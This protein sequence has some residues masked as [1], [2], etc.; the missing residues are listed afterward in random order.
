[1]A[2]FHNLLFVEL[3]GGLGDVLIALAAMQSL[4]RSHPQARLTVLTFAPGGELL[5]TDPLVHQVSY[6]PSGQAYQTV[7]QLLTRQSFDLIVSD[8]SYEGIDR[9]IQA[10]RARRTVTN[11]WRSP[12]PDQ[13][14]SDRFLAILLQEGL[15]QP[16]AIQPAQLHLEDREHQWARACLKPS[17]RP[18]IVLIPD[19]GMAIKRWPVANFIQLGQQLRHQHGATILVP[20]GGDEAGARTI[21]ASIPGAQG[22]PSVNLRQ[23]AALLAQADLVVAADTGPARIAAAVGTPTITLFGPSWAGRYGQPAPHINLQG[24]PACPER[25]IANFTE[26][27]CWYAGTCP[28]EAWQTCL[29][30]ISVKDVLTTVQTLL[31]LRA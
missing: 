31:P 13:F 11:L 14:V 6:A 15:I 25:N 7:A 16:D 12:P 26:Q 19:A 4:A 1:M 10:S 27:A 21:V 29:E 22:W 3:L 30:A 24:L 5:E 9:L 20:V 17:P 2:E 8:T 18:L 28:L 23:L